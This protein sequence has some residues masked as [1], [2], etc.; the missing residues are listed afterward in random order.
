MKSTAS[1]SLVTSPRVI[2]SPRWSRITNKKY[3][4]V[5]PLNGIPSKFVSS[6]SLIARFNFCANNCD[7]DYDS[8]NLSEIQL[9]A[10]SAQI[11]AN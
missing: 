1:P 2:L 11:S 10:V 5:I 8:Y 3:K 9:D 6:T 4:N 7:E